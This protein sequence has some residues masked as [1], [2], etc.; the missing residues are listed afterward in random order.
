MKVMKEWRY[1]LYRCD[2]FLIA[3]LPMPF[4]LT[5]KGRQ[6]CSIR[7]KIDTGTE[8]FERCLNAAVALVS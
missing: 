5:K 8:F 6:I 3:A 7:L 1:S 4:K 2:N